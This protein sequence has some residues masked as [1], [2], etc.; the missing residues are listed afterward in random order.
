MICRILFAGF[1]PRMIA[2]S[3]AWALGREVSPERLHKGIALA[4]AAPGVDLLL[5][6]GL[7][8][9]KARERVT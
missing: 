9:L 4:E 5:S 1:H 6:E 2:G 3:G 7:G 8:A